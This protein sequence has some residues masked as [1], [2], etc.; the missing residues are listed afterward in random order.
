MQDGILTVLMTAVAAAPKLCMRSRVCSLPR[1]RSAR[2]LHT[3]YAK[4]EGCVMICRRDIGVRCSV[5]MLYKEGA[6]GG[7]GGLGVIVRATA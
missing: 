4:Q 3:G 5:M 7:G 2:G 1:A 6:W